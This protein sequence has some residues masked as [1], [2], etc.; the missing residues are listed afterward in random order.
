MFQQSSGQT[1]ELAV[2]MTDAQTFQQSKGQKVQ[3][4][5]DLLTRRQGLLHTKYRR[6]LNYWGLN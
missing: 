1:L 5:T 2:L 3:F 4:N 6:G